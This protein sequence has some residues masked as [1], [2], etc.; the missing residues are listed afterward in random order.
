M[1]SPCHL[2]RTVILA[3]GVATGHC[4]PNAS[5]LPVLLP[6]KSSKIFLYLLGTE[7]RSRYSNYV[8]SWTVK[9]SSP[10]RNKTF[11]SKSSQLQGPD[12]SGSFLVVKR[13]KLEANHSSLFSVDVKNEW[14]YTFL[15]LHVPSRCRQKK[16]YFTF[17]F[18][19][20]GAL[21]FKPRS[22]SL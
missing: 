4:V 20:L 16:L 19:L 13:P 15:H 18:R 3:L 2:T 8:A 10:C 14:S 12:S 1:T 7:R 22:R 6:L 5:S 9:G 11:F 21:N 17:V